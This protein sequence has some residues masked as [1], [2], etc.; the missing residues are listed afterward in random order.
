MVGWAGWRRRGPISP[1]F[2]PR[3]HPGQRLPAAGAAIR[4]RHHP[5]AGRHRGAPRAELARLSRETAAGLRASGRFGFVGDGTLH[6]DAEQALLFRYRYLL[7][8]ETRPEAFTAAALRPKL[9]ALL[10]GLR[11][12]ASP[13]LARYGFAD[14]TGAFLGLA[15]TWLGES[16]VATEDGAWFAPGEVPRVLLVAR[17]QGAGLDA[18]AQRLAIVAF[19]EAFAAANPPAGARLLLS[20]PGVFAAEAAA[21]IERDV[22]RLTLLATLLLAGFLVWRFRSLA[23]L[24]LVA[25]PPLAAMLAGY[26]AVVALYGSVHAIALGFGVTML[27]VVVDYPILLL[28]L[29]RP[30]EP[31]GTAAARIW[32][33]LRLSAVSAA[34]GLLAMVG[35]GLPGLVQTGLFAGAGLL[36]AAA[37]TRWL[38][39]R[40]VPEEARLL[41]RPMN[42]P[43][44][45][46]ATG[47][48]R[49]SRCWLRPRP[50]CWRPAGRT[51]SATWR[52]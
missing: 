33:T 45:R 40:L 8:P 23:V 20:G 26:A 36:T 18:E 19:H 43:L 35:S 46:S 24:A 27:G 3:P 15:V 51:G 39:P 50:C 38:L 31:L 30:G 25:V 37:T 14:P 2:C 49:P 28:T 11:S 12:A 21:T 6:G 41:A 9:E 13:L 32:P 7:S 44:P 16:H 1:N 4:R 22:R 52:R 10:D 5:A 34:A 42:L 17:G 47:P 48:S 29:R